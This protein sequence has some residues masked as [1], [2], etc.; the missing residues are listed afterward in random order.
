MFFFKRKKIHLDCFTQFGVIANNCPIEKTSEF[1]PDWWKGL[2]KVIKSISNFGV[3][4]EN[5]TMRS[6]M[7]FA[8]LYRLGVTIPLW[9]DLNIRA[10]NDNYS[11]QFKLP[12]SSISEHPP[13]QSGSTFKDFIHLKISNNWFFK[14]KTGV[15][16]LLTE[17]PWEKLLNYPKMQIMSGVLNFNYQHTCN[18][19]AFLSKENQPYQYNLTAGMPLAQLVPLSDKQVEPH[20]HVISDVE[21]TNI[22][23]AHVPNKFTFWGQTNKKNYYRRKNI[24]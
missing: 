11:Y 21:Y 20:I 7:G 19:N 9:S 15:D 23:R 22:I 4:I 16:F 10:S 3:E 18:I 24:K 17:N 14:E 2:P 13:E 6:C 12:N 1:I 8:E 5:P